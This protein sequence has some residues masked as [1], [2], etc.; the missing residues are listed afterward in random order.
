MHVGLVKVCS[1]KLLCLRMQQQPGWQSLL[2]LTASRP[3]QNIQS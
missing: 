3:F 2:V 1:D